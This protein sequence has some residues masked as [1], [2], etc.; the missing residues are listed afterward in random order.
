[1][2]IQNKMHLLT[3]LITFILAQIVQ[4]ADSSDVAFFTRLVN[5][6]QN[7]QQDYVK[8]M[9]TATEDVPSD[10]TSIAKEIQTYRDD[11]YTTLIDADHINMN[12]LESFASQLPW[13]SKRLAGGGG[14]SNSKGSSTSKGQ[15]SSESGD[16]TPTTE[17]NWIQVTTADYETQSSSTGGVNRVIAPAGLSFIVMLVSLI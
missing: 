13:Y 2:K 5:D 17:F 15:S 12:Q 4:A 8:Y 6:A 9:K 11:S 1:M 3:L 7:H 16:S 14:G 10:F